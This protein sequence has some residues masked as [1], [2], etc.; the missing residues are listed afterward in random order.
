MRVSHFQYYSNAILCR[1]TTARAAELSV[2]C[3][4]L[5]DKLPT[6]SSCLHLKYTLFCRGSLIRVRQVC[7]FFQAQRMNLQCS[8][9]CIVP[10]ATTDPPHYFHYRTW[11]VNLTPGHSSV[12]HCG[13]H[14][15]RQAIR[16]VISRPLSNLVLMETATPYR[17]DKPHDIRFASALQ[18]TVNRPQVITQ[19]R[20]ELLLLSY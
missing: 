10:V 5:L 6:L 3:S 14:L 2:D 11:L 15:C 1:Y 12:F 8:P 18:R 7:C 4:R 20:L 16:N 19:L 9:S 13:Y 17:P